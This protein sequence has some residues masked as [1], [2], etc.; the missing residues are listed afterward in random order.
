MPS[1][2]RGSILIST[3]NDI[4]EAL[5]EKLGGV[6]YSPNEWKDKFNLCGIAPIDSAPA[7]SVLADSAGTGDERGSILIATADAIGA[8]LNKKY[9]VLRGFKPKE[10]ASACRKMKALE[11]GSV[12]SASIASFSDGADTVPLTSCVCSIDANLDGKSAVNAVHARKNLLD[13][14]AREETTRNGVISSITS[15]GT[16]TASGQSTGNGDIPVTLGASISLKSGQTYT[17]SI[18]GTDTR[19]GS[20]YVYFAGGSYIS[21]NNANHSGTYTPS[22]NQTI[23]GITLRMFS[24]QSITLEAKI[25][26]E[27]GSSATT[28]EPYQTPETKTADLG[29]AVYGGS[30]DIIKGEGKE[31][32][33]RVK[34]S[35]LTWSI[36]T[37]S[38][39]SAFVS[40]QVTGLPTTSPKNVLCDVL[41]YDGEKTI[42]AMTDKTL[43]TWTNTFRVYDTDC[44]DVTEFLNTYG[45]GFIVYQL[46]E[47]AQVDFTFDPVKI[48]SFPGVNNI[49]ND[50]GNTAVEYYQ[51]PTPYTRK[52]ATGGIANFSDQRTDLP[53]TKAVA[54]I[55]P[56][57][58][59]KSAVN[60]Y[61]GKKNLLN[62]NDSSYTFQV[63]DNYRYNCGTVSLKKGVTYTFS[64]LQEDAL[65]SN[66]R[67]TLAIGVDEVYTYE[68]ATG[69]N[70]HNQSG[71]HSMQYTPAED[72]EAV[73][74]VWV[75]TPSNAVKYSDFM[76]EVGSTASAYV[77]YQ[78]PTTY[79]AELGETVYGGSVDFVSGE[80]TK[81][82]EKYSITGQ[83]TGDF[84]T[85][86][87][88]NGNRI[89][90]RISG[91]QTPLYTGGVSNIGENRACLASAT[92]TIGSWCIYTDNKLYFVVPN[93]YTNFATALQY[94]VDNN[95]TFV[96]P[97]ATPTE[98][99]IPGR[100]I[101]PIEGV[102]NYWNDAGGDTEI[103]YF[104]NEA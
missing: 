52:T 6:G 86:T 51:A 15:D 89:G 29:R 25:M 69:T 73:F 63:G 50:C 8:I 27:V 70:Y 74:L 39:R 9:N 14:P 72:C 32:S 59:G 94:L 97:L 38:G 31:T 88:N 100:V 98:S 65:T 35:D 95:A 49:W 93:E 2:T 47:S 1:T 26:L 42:G 33:A 44:E 78:A 81:T 37:V 66:T 99:A 5:V 83:E 34:I 85:G 55:A 71:V 101:S 68:S 92:W 18:N 20:V 28:Y 23:T 30:A 87:N 4:G 13:I 36:Q 54:N 19:T 21:I 90:I 24:G 91:A 62:A 12:A 45:N 7:L 61:Q 60:L 96:F 41:T 82:Y 75:H 17:F 64:A 77:P 22:A 104:E 10:W 103:Q 53:L 43:V 67:N 84:L 48:D 16:I 102:N 46:V 80:V 40:G 76:L 3:A 11:E 56:S 79:T 57:I 58:A